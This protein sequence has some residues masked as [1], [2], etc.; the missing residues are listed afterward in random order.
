M[1]VSNHHVQRLP[2]D[3]G[4]K[5]AQPVETSLK[6]VMIEGAPI[7]E[8]AAQPTGWHALLPA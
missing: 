4:L 1:S 6:R 7:V 3:L 2:V 8:Q 5:L